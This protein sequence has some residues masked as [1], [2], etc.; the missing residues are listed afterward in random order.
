MALAIDAISSASASS[1]STL[2]K[3]HTC[4]GTNRVLSVA[5]AHGDASNVS[6]TNV[7]YNGVALSKA[8]ERQL[9]PGSVYISNW[10][11]IAPDTGAHDLVVTLNTVQNIG[12]GIFSFTGAD[13][14]SQPDNTASAAALGGN[15]GY[16]GVT[17]TTAYDNSIIVQSL[18][19]IG[20]GTIGNPLDSQT[21]QYSLA[22]PLTEGGTY[23][24]TTA[25]SVTL[26]WGIGTTN[27]E[28]AMVAVGI[29]TSQTP[30]PSPSISPSQSPSSS[31][32]PSRSPSASPSKSPSQSPSA[33]ASP[34]VSPSASPSASPS[35]SPSASPSSSISPSNSPS[36][37]PSTSVSPSSSPSAS[38]STSVSPSISPSSSPSTSISP[39]SSPSESPSSSPSE[40]PSSSA[41]PSTSPSVSPSP[42]PADWDNQT[43]HLS[44][45]SRRSKFSS[46]WDNQDKSLL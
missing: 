12:V 33:S 3:S 11:L 25:G 21:E 1:S 17:I 16:L 23:A 36:A 26:D 5:V 45:W 2:T 28:V 8:V 22:T 15:D 13:Q 43:K 42:S 10:I 44:I 46:T 27:V 20:T 7:T 32:S 6:I 37:S 19:S 38:P 41:S 9:F 24:T 40:S 29:K 30:S 35:N 4:S 31:V 39:S 14:T 34:S 18:I